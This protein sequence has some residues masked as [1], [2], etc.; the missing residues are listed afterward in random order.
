MSQ[1]SSTGDATIKTIGE[2][3]VAHGR[4]VIA[5][6]VVA[7][8]AGIATREIG[9]VRDVG[10]GGSRMVGRLRETV[11]A[12]FGNAGQGV[13]VEVGEHE[14]AIDVGIVAYYGVALHELAAAV[15]R[16]VIVAVERMTGLS[17]TEVNVTVHDVYFEGEDE[18][19][20]G[21]TRPR[22]R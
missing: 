21:E 14:A 7:K 2:P 20:D 5:D 16:N 6:T 3:A 15:R 19:G 8:I 13:S 12:A 17:V 22:V 11:P 18:G 4:T 9:G 10:G 1:P